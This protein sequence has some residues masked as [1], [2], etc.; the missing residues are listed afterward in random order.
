MTKTSIKLFKKTLSITLAFLITILIMPNF[1]FKVKAANWTDEGNYDISWYVGNEGNSTFSISTAQQLAGLA[2][3]VNS[4]NNFAGKTINLTADIVL[5]ANAQDYATWGTTPPA[6]T[7]TAIGNNDNDLL[8][9]FDG[10][11]HTIAGIYINNTVSYQG[12]FGK[13]RGIIKNV[14]IINS[15][16]KGGYNTGG[17]VGYN[18]F[19]TIINC[20]N[21]GTI[22]GTGNSTGGIVGWSFNG[23]V[24]NCYNTGTV[25]GDNMVGGVVGENQ[26]STISNCYNTGVVSGTTNVGGIAGT[27]YGTN[28]TVTNCYYFGCNAGI[29]GTGASQAGTTPF[30]KIANNPL[31]TGKT[32]TITEQTTADINTSWSSSLGSD[33]SVAYSNNYS[34][35]DTSKA[36]VNGTTLIGVS[37]G[38]ST[39]SGRTM[40]IKQNGLTATGFNG[41]VMDIT[42]PISLPLSINSAGGGTVLVNAATPSFSNFNIVGETTYAKNDTA[43]ALNG[44]ATV[45]DGGTVTYQ[46]YKNTTN[47]SLGATEISGATNATY[48]PP[49]DTMGTN[50]YYVIVINTNNSVNGNKTVSIMSGTKKIVVNGNVSA[51]APSFNTNLSGSTTYNKNV[52]ATAL[53]GT[54]TV[55][56]TGTVSYQWYKNTTN[57]TTG[58]NAISGATNATYTPPTDAVGTSYYYVIA[59]NTNNSATGNKIATATSEFK[60]IVV[61]AVS[62]PETKTI[63]II[64]TP[65]AI[66]NPGKISVKPVG[67]AF[68]QSVEV[69]IKDDPTVKKAIE[70]ALD[71]IIKNELNETTIFSLDIN[72]YIKGTD[73][74]V[75]PNEGTS[76]VITIPIPESL[77]AN[78]DNI[79]VV[80]IIDGKLTVLKTKVVLIDGVYCVQFTATH[81][82]PYAMVVD[83]AN[84]LSDATNPKTSG[85]NTVGTF[86]IIAI[87][88]VV[89]LAVARKKRK[90]K[91]VK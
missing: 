65:T 55:T 61:N 12:L 2:S 8:G 20:Y 36:T 78:K 73:T 50:Y 6:N 40:T 51:V 44:T 86:S 45:S 11:G 24:T 58:G 46:W 79:K 37:A 19:G 75:Q 17:I 54:A 72:L 64:Q 52:T 32:T 60:K 42:V 30:V 74:K 63:D 35:S 68:T 77:L 1:D 7:W 33:F 67:E 84:E 34:L 23:T 85:N 38:N 18:A 9:T 25:S 83:T 10:K 57:S 66:K 3:L 87:L 27:S 43:T 70:D 91:I 15:Y 21:E 29:G 89:T 88:S 48:T 69:R 39:I 56:D 49:T 13:S 62:I 5:N 26:G 22:I 76:V 14:G 82:S 16:I 47:G 53:N 41:D 90:F 59:T 4:G 31:G 81:F 28:P 71:D 80:C